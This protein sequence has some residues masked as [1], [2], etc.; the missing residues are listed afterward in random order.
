MVKVLDFGLVKLGR[1]RDDRD[2]IGK[3]AENK[4]IGTPAFLPPEMAIGE[5]EIDGRADIYSLGCVAYYLLTGELV[6]EGETAMKTVVAHAT[7][8]PVPP[9]QRSENPLP[10]SLEKI[11]LR[12][13]AKKPEQ[14]PAS[15][16][17]LA[18]LLEQVAFEQPWTDESARKWWS[19]NLS[20]ALDRRPARDGAPPTAFLRPV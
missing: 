9:S 15:A 17:E 14:R 8:E 1:S 10:E 13:L 4:I 6:F 5:G 7:Q 3:T 2:D 12:C 20:A 16:L 11:I 18:G 19:D